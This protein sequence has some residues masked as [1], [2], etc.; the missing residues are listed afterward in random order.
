MTT[1]PHAYAIGVDYGTNSVRAL[2][3][4]VRNGAEIGTGVFGYPSG[5]LGVLL[6]VR[7]PNLARQHPGDYLEGFVASVRLALAEAALN[8][9]FNVARVMGI[10]VDTTGSSPM[11]TNAEGIPLGMTPEFRHH[12]DAQC[13]LWKDHTSF[14]EA[15]EIT[16]LARQMGRPYLDRCGGTYSSEWFWAKILH[17]ARVAPEVF[18]AA[19]SWIELADFVPAAIT[20][21]L[22]PD[23]I[24]R[25]ICAAGHK[26]MFADDPTGWGGLPDA[27]FLA[28]LDPRLAELRGR[29]YSRAVPSDV[30]AGRLTEEYAAMTGLPAGTPVAAGAFDAH[31]GAVG[32]GLRPG[33]LVKIMGTSSCDITVVEG[34]ANVPQVPGLCGVVPGSVLPGDVGLEAGQSAVGDLFA[35]FVR[36]LAP[37]EVAGAD[38]Y[39]KLSEAATA[40][41]P[42]ESGLLA[43]D[44]NNGNR[45]VLVDPLLSGLLIGQTLRT[46]APEIFR[47]LIEATAFG[48]LMIIERIEECGVKIDEVVVCGGI[49]EKSP[50]TMGV[51]ADVLNRPIRTSRSAQTCALGAA[52]FGAV[53]GGAHATTAEAQSAMTGLKPDAVVPNPERVATYRQLFELYRQLHDAFG[54]AG[55]EVPLAGLMKELLAI[56]RAVRGA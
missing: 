50:L 9:E 14:A 8:P 54:V 47:A 32:V 27:E 2:V 6:D 15:A 42:G 34:L 3:V 37:P 52:V 1:S 26:A 25:S 33:T 45:C 17:C 21:N 10:G 18:A 48:S 28:A 49:A 30:L 31:H 36:E 7:D 22:A 56:R 40:L 41:A 53:V 12:L 20:G 24:V 44:W 51:Y 29:L 5:D 46:T 13:W 35:W 39:A 19:T 55:A 4:D 11:P 16:Q 38:S 43:L 23:Q